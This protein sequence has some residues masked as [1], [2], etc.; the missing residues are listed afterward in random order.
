MHLTSL[1]S[2]GVGKSPLTLGT[3]N[4][5]LLPACAGVAIMLELQNRFV[6]PAAHYVE[7]GAIS[8]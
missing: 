5:L 6:S 3:G 2:M 1:G 4:Q 8:T 7:N